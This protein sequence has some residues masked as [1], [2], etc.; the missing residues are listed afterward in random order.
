MLDLGATW[1]DTEIKDLIQ[2]CYP[3][4][5]LAQ[6]CSIDLTNDGIP[7]S[8]DLEGNS[9]PVAPDLSYRLLARY[10]FFLNTM[11]FDAF[12]QVS[13]TWQDD[14]QYGLTYDPLTVQ[15]AYGLTDIVAGIHDKE[16]RYEVSLFGK[17]I[18][19]KE[20]FSA[21]DAANG[22]IGRLYARVPRQG[23]SYYGVRVKY[24]F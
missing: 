6:G 13:Y 1:M 17:N 8:Q 19:D 23:Q 4:Q 5:T 10:D 2:P 18:G 12:A 15:K 20:F 16:G 22:T 24:N 3:G 21:L 9:G 7:E 11:P 14:I